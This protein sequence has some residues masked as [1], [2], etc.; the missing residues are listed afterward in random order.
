MKKEVKKL[1]KEKI[2]KERSLDCLKN[3]GRNMWESDEMYSNPYYDKDDYKEYYDWWSR[4]VER[5]EP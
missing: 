4:N 5:Y 3:T 1:I 2:L